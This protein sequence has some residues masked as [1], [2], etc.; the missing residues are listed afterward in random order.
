MPE[1]PLI[2]I[3]DDEEDVRDL[4]GINLRRAGYETDEAA[5][6]LEALQHVRTNPPDAI[7]LDIKMP[8]RDGLTVCQELRSN[9]ST[10]HIPIIM[11]T[12]LGQPEDR[13]AGLEKG[14]DDYV[15]KPFHIRELILR[16]QSLLRRP[17]NQSRGTEMTKGPFHFELAAVRLTVNAE[18]VELT[19]LEFKLIHLLASRNGDIVERDTIL[20]ELWGQSVHV[21]TRT[22]NTHVKRLRE[23]LGEYSEWI[24][25]ARGQGYV[26]EAPEVS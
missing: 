11:L 25:T 9:E 6:G 5:D 13:I 12:A 21:R 23:K 22:L 19:L 26:F 20:K 1:K 3:V 2:L 8:G 4:V 10:R 17:M 18:I 24:H 14:A 16:V 15:S 7:L